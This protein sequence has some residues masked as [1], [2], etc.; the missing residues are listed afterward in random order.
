MY[1]TCTE[2]RLRYVTTKEINMYMTCT[3]RGLKTDVF[4]YFY[5]TGR[6]C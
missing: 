4:F 5:E 1:M 2:S 6:V 3:E